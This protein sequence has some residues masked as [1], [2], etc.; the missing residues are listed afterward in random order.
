LQLLGQSNNIAY[1][2]NVTNVTTP[3]GTKTPSL[4]DVNSANLDRSLYGVAIYPGSVNNDPKGVG[5][6]I[7]YATTPLGVSKYVY[8]IYNRG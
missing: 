7:N 6:G 1:V 8:S 4:F 5:L 3:C 2:G